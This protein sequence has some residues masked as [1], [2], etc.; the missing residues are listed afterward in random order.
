M[1][2]QR[3][4]FL[5]LLAG[6]VALPAMTRRAFAL[7]Y[8]TRPVR[9][10]VG[11]P[12]GIAPDIFTR[13]AAQGLSE[14]LGQQ[15]IVDN[16]P[17]ANSNI[18]TEMVVR[19]APDGY[20]LLTVTATNAINA[21]LY[22][23]HLTFDLLRDLAPVG[24]LMRSASVIQVSPS[25]PV[26]TLAEFIAYAK[27][28][29]GKL[30]YASAGAGSATN[31]GGELFKL[32]TGIDL[33]HIAYHSNYLPDLMS[34][35]VQASFSPVAQSIEFIKAG[36]LRALAV[37]SATRLDALPDIP[38][39]N[40]IVPGYEAYVW[41]AL[42]APANTPADVID[43][44]NTALNQ[45]LSTPEMKARYAKL[46]AEPMIVTPAEFGKFLAAETEKWGKVIKTAHIKAE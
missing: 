8:P 41:D 45:A 23:G 34:G 22:E 4:T 16:R 5:R 31:V 28:N 38:A 13:L 12:A 20:T 25:V 19:A 11:Y 27:A 36:K 15:F 21:T 24:G 44:I 42:G 18:A 17:G 26:K 3:R 9:I 32:M 1:K 43:K 40:E 35:Q 10:L 7:D 39:A 37:T 29:P 14:R 46:G 33:V 30:N 6:A 2:T